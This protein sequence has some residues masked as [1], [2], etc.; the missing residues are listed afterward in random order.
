MHWESDQHQDR[1]KD[2]V[3]LLTPIVPK[4][5]SAPLSTW[6]EKHSPYNFTSNHQTFTVTRILSERECVPHPDFV[7]NGGDN[8]NG[9]AGD[10]TVV[11]KVET[12]GSSEQSA[13]NTGTA[14][15]GDEQKTPPENASLKMVKKALMAWHK[16]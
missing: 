6:K 10:D 1:K 12:G 5:S 11:A 8:N 14:P 9:P 3:L 7:N 4:K 16:L 13:M 2:G 15:T